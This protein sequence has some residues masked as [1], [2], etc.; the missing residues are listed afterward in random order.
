MTDST[1]KVEPPQ[2]LDDLMMAMDIVDELRHQDQLVEKELSEADRDA[3]FKKRL[4]E[5]Y[6]SQGLEV[7]D[8]M[9][10]EGIKALK[11]ARFTY[12]RKGTAMQ[13]FWAGLWVRRGRTAVIGGAAVAAVS[14]YSGATVWD[15][16]KETR[17]RQAVQTELTKTLPQSLD[18]ARKLALNE[19]KTAD[20]RQA[21]ERYAAAGTSAL[22]AKDR[23]AAQKAISNLKSL[24]VSLLQDYDLRIVSRAN[25]RTGLYRVPNVNSGARNYYIVVEPVSR[26]GQT[27]SIPVKSEED[28]STSTVNKFAV[29]VPY[30]TFQRIA[31]DKQDDG[32]IQNNVL[33][34]KPRG[35]LSLEFAMPASAAFITKW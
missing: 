15:N 18:E 3:A 1:Q 32:I 21:A 22:A 9:L 29:R 8:R 30:E 4:R 10:E 5:I 35:A 26:E 27:L 17:S 2:R 28:G 33:A 12:R 20:A 6:E 19:A 16:V 24:R 14:L 31:A 11:E 13:R 34:R 25:E 23:T 7:N